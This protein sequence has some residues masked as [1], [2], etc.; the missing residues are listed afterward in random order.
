MACFT[1]HINVRPGCLVP[2]VLKVVVLLEVSRVTFGAHIIPVL[3]GTR[4]VSDIVVR[5]ILI[6]VEVNPAL[7]SFLER[8]TVPAN[9]QH[10]ITSA[11]KFDQ[12]LLE[13]SDTE[14]LCDCIVLEHPV[15]PIRP[16][17]EFSLALK[18]R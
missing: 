10:L 17:D 6:R 14:R 9:T 1:R 5:D 13:G 4:P 8:P 16:H 2:V 15:R 12:I 11:R 7:T 3:V 18:E